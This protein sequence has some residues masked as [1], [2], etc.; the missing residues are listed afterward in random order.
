[1]ADT[2]TAASISVASA[3]VLTSPSTEDSLPDSPRDI[4]RPSLDEITPNLV[5]RVDRYMKQVN[6]KSDVN[7]RGDPLTPQRSIPVD[8]RMGEDSADNGRVA[9]VHEHELSNGLATPLSHSLAL[10]AISAPSPVS[11]FSFMDSASQDDQV[12]SPSFFTRCLC[13]LG[14]INLFL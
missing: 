6:E 11:N 2:S 10:S 12:S 13:G 14:V 5:E 7:T 3:T 4:R 8:R 9:S 1:M